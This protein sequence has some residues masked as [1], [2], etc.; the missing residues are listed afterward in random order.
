MRLLHPQQ[1]DGMH[2]ELRNFDVKETGAL[3]Q[4]RTALPSGEGFGGGER[5]LS[6][7]S[8]DE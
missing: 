1:G 8:Q 5:P 4:N 3:N 2:R 6:R 7:R